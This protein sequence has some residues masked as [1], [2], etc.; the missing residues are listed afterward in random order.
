MRKI[1]TFINYHP[2]IICYSYKFAKY[3]ILM[4]ILHKVPYSHSLTK[5]IFGHLTSQLCIYQSEQI[6]SCWHHTSSSCGQP[7]N[8]YTKKG[9]LPMFI[10][11]HRTLYSSLAHQTSQHKVYCL[12]APQVRLHQTSLS[13][14][15]TVSKKEVRLCDPQVQRIM[16]RLLL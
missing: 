10:S 9:S 13:N 5:S 8:M 11:V 4:I 3:L 2:K 1:V 12:S 16:M 6:D 7:S 14:L 15:S